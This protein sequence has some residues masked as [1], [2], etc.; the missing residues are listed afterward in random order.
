MHTSIH[1]KFVK[2]LKYYTN[3]NKKSSILIAISGGQDSLCLIQLVETSNIIE[4]Y[5]KD[6]EYIYIDH[7]WRFDSKKQIKHLINYIN[8]TK[9]KI[10]IYQI[11]YN[12]MSELIARRIRYQILIK[13]AKIHQ[14]QII[15]TG[16]NKTDHLETFF[17][18]LIRGTGLEGLSSI[19]LIRKIN[20][21]THLLRPLIEINRADILWFCRKC[22]LPI[23]S[24]KT[25][26]NYK[27]YRNRIR[28]EILP[29]LKQYFSPQIE[30]NISN[31]LDLSSL[32]NEYIKQNAIKLYIISR[33]RNYIAMNYKFIKN[34]HIALQK[35]VLQI[36][37]YYHFNKFLNKKIIY[38]IIENINKDHI[39]KIVI[40]WHNLYINMYKNW[41]Y[42]K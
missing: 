14:Q 28:H 38:E 42:I 39:S 15:C 24:D 1:Q 2:A 29:Y 41:I 40:I 17:V 13:H 31:F 10:S 3:L 5:F 4:K 11:N 37:F 12:N 36:F 33:D 9:H 26:F 16:H 30:K 19:P 27:N 23:W 25:N 6:I 7:Q 32:E 8:T 22:N 20:K 18:N 34:Q 21:Q 35:R